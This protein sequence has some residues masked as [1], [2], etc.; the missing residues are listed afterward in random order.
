[1]N[2]NSKI[3]V[4]MVG[5]DRDVQG[6]MSTVVNLYYK[7]GLDTKV[8]LIYIPTYKEGGII[9]KI[10]IFI[11]GF[12]QFVFYCISIGST[13]VHIHMAQKGSFARKMIIFSAAKVFQKKTIIHLHG[14]EFEIF[15]TKNR[16][17]S[18]L[19]KYVFNNADVV[20]VLSR[21]WKKK[22]SKFS[23]NENIIVLYNPAILHEKQN[24]NI[25]KILVLFLGRLGKRKGIYDLLNCV[26][27]NNDYFVKKNVK[28]I[29]AGDGE[30]VK[31]REIVKSNDL[32]K[33]VEIPGWIT[34]K[35]KER[36]LET[37]D[38][39]ILP[40]YNEQMPMSVLE[41]MGYGYPIISTNVAAIPEMV[42]HGKNGSLMEPGDIDG[43]TKALKQLCEDS[44]MRE[45]MGK[46]S[47]EIV[48]EKFESKMI[49]EKLINVYKE[50][51]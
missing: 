42:K 35:Q 49:I 6:G 1:M 15:M 26:I 36:Y 47:Q 22:L 4:I 18:F 21:L 25:N 5:T 28:F 24:K 14:S 45:R 29:L 2:N 31:V 23:T 40:S 37:S 12:I 8:N 33:I 43:L 27:M 41:G 16:V 30:V 11:K 10:V 7:A 34:G 3:N 51:Q 13:I 19:T 44:S 32:E 38:I 17:C 39:L 48:I 50:L 20:F 9:K 46:K